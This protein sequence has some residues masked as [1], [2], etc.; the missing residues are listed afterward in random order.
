MSE[1][2]SYWPQKVSYLLQTAFLSVPFEEMTLTAARSI[3]FL[4]GLYHY[5]GH[6]AFPCLFVVVVWQ[7]SLT[8]CLSVS[9]DRK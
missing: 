5:L 8:Y 2:S 9:L 4:I 3:G 1:Y 6:E 7:I